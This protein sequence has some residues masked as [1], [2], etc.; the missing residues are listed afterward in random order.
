MG[1]AGLEWLKSQP[2]LFGL[3]MYAI[4]GHAERSGVI[5]EIVSQADRASV[6][7]SLGGKV[8]NIDKAPRN[9]YRASSRAPSAISSQ[10]RSA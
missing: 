5:G 10:K 1:N 4:S 6:A 7:K 3:V 9:L 2:E 8:S